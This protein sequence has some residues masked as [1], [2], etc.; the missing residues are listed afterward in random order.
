MRNSEEH[1]R[2]DRHSGMLTGPGQH[3]WACLRYS[4]HRSFH[5]AVCRCLGPPKILRTLHQ[6]PAFCLLC[7]L[8][9]CNKDCNRM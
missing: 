5:V 1:N 6:V 3:G 4:C 9:P 2:N 8:I 7:I